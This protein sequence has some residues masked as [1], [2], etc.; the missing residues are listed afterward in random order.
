MRNVA[1]S[2]GIGEEG[3]EEE[4]EEEGRKRK[5]EWKMRE[6]I[7]LAVVE[8][9]AHITDALSALELVNSGLCEGAVLLPAAEI[10]LV[11]PVCV[12]DLE[13]APFLVVQ[14][15]DALPAVVADVETGKAGAEG[16]DG[17]V[18]ESAEDLAVLLLAGVPVLV[19]AFDVDP[20]LAVRDVVRANVLV[21][22]GH[23]LSIVAALGAGEHVEVHVLHASVPRALRRLGAVGVHV[24]DR[25]IAAHNGEFVALLVDA[26]PSGLREQGGNINTKTCLNTN[27][28]N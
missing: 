5:Q 2:H 13:V 11:I 1:S 22:T 14:A 12:P 4:E 23:L 17:S 16:L 27:N 3:E 7:L 24:V 21:E 28:S 25:T 10:G 8:I 9:D 6:V 19:G 20:D 15:Q 26:V 18:A